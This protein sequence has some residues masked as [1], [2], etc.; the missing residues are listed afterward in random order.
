MKNMCDTTGSKILYE[1]S[2]MFKFGS[3]PTTPNPKMIRNVDTDYKF[4]SYKKK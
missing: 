3:K 1:S 4:V 2:V